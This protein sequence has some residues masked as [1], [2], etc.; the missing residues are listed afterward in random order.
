MARES[1][2]K[3]QAE[4]FVHTRSHQEVSP[5]GFREDCSAW[6][7]RTNLNLQD[8]DF[9]QIFPH[10][11]AWRGKEEAAATMPPRCLPSARARGEAHASDCG[12]CPMLPPCT[13]WAD[14]STALHQ[15]QLYHR[16]SLTPSQKLHD[17]LGVIKSWNIEPRFT[18][19]ETARRVQQPE[20]LRM[21][22]LEIALYT[23]RLAAKRV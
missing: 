3:E 6:S 13:K 12:L 20:P 15:T 8:L 14:F 23:R 21:L 17:S 1:I 4:E 11:R 19:L 22:L 10:G 2:A 7:G 18:S 9:E 5:I 16:A